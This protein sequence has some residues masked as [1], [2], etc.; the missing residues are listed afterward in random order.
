MDDKTIDLKDIVRVIKKRWRIIGATFL[1]VVILV[2]V[3]TFLTPPTYQ[4]ETTLRIKQ[5]KSLAS[6]L[7]SDATFGN[8]NATKEQM[9]TY[10][11]ILKSRTVV[12]KV[13]DTTQADK[14]KPPSYNGM[15]KR[16]TTQAVKD[17]EIL[18]VRVKASSP[19]EAQFVANTLVNTF[20][21]RMQEL[22]RTEQGA[23]RQ[24]I[25]ERLADAKK[26]LEKNE[27]AL[28]DFKRDQKIVVPEEE[29]KAMVARHAAVDQMSADNAVAIAA[30]QARLASI[31]H[32]LNGQSPGVIADSPLI[33][34]YK[35]K[36]A[37]LEV[38][39]VSLRQNFTDKH[40]QVTATKAAIEETK[41]SLSAEISRVLNAEA[42]SANPIYQGLIQAKV[43][44]QAE[45]SAAAAQL[46]AIN[47][48]KAVSDQEMGQLPSKEQV[49]VKLTREADVSKQVYLM[50]AQRYEEA[51]IS[52]IMQPTDVQVIDT[53]VPDYRPIS[54][55]LVLNILI[56]VVLGL[57]LGTA[58]AFLYEYM[59]R[60]VRTAEDVKQYLDLPVLGSIPSYKHSEKLMNRS[61]LWSKLKVRLGI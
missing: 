34:Q 39:L 8:S 25:G 22:V 35:G 32:E 1:V 26:D 21:A 13:I 29:A 44:N 15:L 45:L 31:D 19:E 24:F 60:T 5:P 18:S 27:A 14:E 9:S 10:A 53:A 4:A 3:I 51:R 47:Q 2:A 41:A 33:Q 20:L 57:F 48:V 61:S 43:Q 59:N 54:P 16:I 42:P 40:P 28:E 50:L 6:S 23:V 38:N 37:E 46:G 49:L 30:S 36:L 12:E 17:T 7:L 52:E 56:G 55:R 58:L 11:E